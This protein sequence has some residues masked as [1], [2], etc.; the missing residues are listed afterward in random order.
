MDK[1]QPLIKHR[2]WICFG[3]SVIFVLVGWWMASGAI[4]TEI[5]NGRK[6]VDGA[7][8]KAK[9]GANDPN[10]KWVEAA[11]ERNKLDKAAFTSASTELRERQQNARQWPES[12]RDEMRR[13]SVPGSDHEPDFPR[14][15]GID[16]QG[17]DRF[18]AGHC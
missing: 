7:F 17:R 10:A 5:E 4:A 12:V 2:Y 6:A 9:Q 11:N 13:N 3:L 14:E 16:L 8:S 1:L 18:T 15:V